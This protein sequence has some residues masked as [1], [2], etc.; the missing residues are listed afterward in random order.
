MIWLNVLHL[1]HAGYDV[2]L[3]TAGTATCT[4]DA[5]GLIPTAL[6]IKVCWSSLTLWIGGIDLTSQAISDNLSLRALLS[7]QGQRLRLRSRT[8]RRTRRLRYALRSYLAPLR[9]GNDQETSPRLSF[10]AIASFLDTLVTETISHDDLFDL[11][12]H[13]SVSRHFRIMDNAQHRLSLAPILQR[14]PLPAPVNC[15]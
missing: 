9:Y 15:M 12:E 2:N 3:E 7:N 13:R 4:G 10:T 14:R 5:L 8:P 6:F 1:W 11:L